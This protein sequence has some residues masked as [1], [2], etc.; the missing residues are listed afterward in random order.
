MSDREGE[1]PKATGFITR[2]L[3]LD[4]EVGRRDAR[5]HQFAAVRG[6]SGLALTY[7]KGEVLPPCPALMALLPGCRC[8]WGIT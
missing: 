7:G 1:L 6:D 5:I 3:S 4:L 8:Y 2:C